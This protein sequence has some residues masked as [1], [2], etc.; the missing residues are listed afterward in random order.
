VCVRA[1]V[2]ITMERFVWHACKAR[3]MYKIYVCTGYINRGKLCVAYLQSTG[4]VCD[5]YICALVVFHFEDTLISRSVL[6]YCSLHCSRCIVLLFPA[7]LVIGTGMKRQPAERGSTARATPC[8]FV[9]F[10]NIHSD[11][12]CG[13]ALRRENVFWKEL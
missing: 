12:S 11:W 13:G 2:I 6:L 1:L 9:L 5:T 8:D 7:V 4:T 10:K 3:V